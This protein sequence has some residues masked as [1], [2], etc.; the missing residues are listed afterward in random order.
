MAQRRHLTAPGNSKLTN[1]PSPPEPATIPP[2]MPIDPQVFRRARRGNIRASI[3]VMSECYPQ[4][5]RLAYGLSGRDD[6]GRGVVQY[7]MRHGLRQLSTWSNEGEPMRWT[8]HHTL[9][10]TRRAARHQP[11]VTNDTLIKRAQTENAY[12]AAF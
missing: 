12:Y 3:A 4:M 2:T 5:Y 9:L 7:V 6:V 8:R 10:T 1:H 11:D